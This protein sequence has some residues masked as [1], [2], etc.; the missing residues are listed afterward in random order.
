MAL[1]FPNPSRSYDAN[2]NRV[3]FCGYDSIV[4]ITF[5]VDATVM[6]RLCPQMS[7]NEAGFLKA[8]D[9]VRKK[10]YTA[11]QQV[12]GRGH[13]KGVAIAFNLSTED[14]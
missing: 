2:K 8:F 13:R 1:N 6:H 14:F 5:F 9:S 4:E 10:I 11:A 12:Y 3:S 7:D